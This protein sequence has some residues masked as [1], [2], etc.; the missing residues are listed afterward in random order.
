MI[1]S[2]TSIFTC[3]L[4]LASETLV[5][6][7]WK[8]ESHC[9]EVHP[10]A[11][12]CAVN[13]LHKLTLRHILNFKM[14]IT[15]WVRVAVSLFP[16]FGYSYRV[17]SSLTIL[18]TDLQ[19]VLHSFCWT[20]HNFLSLLTQLSLDSTRLAQDLVYVQCTYEMLEG[21]LQEVATLSR[22]CWPMKLLWYNLIYRA[23]LC[24]PAK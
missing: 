20:L 22:C 9:G 11:Q 5:F 19:K 21:F 24:S 14:N 18:H 15:L 10:S 4:S 1:G 7:W 23:D 12:C 17:V 2:S 6:I 8:S 3:L 13:E 16:H